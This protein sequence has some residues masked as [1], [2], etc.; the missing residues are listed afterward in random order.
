MVGRLRLGNTA[1]ASE[2]DTGATGTQALRGAEAWSL[3]SNASSDDLVNTE[4]LIP[5]Q[6]GD[7]EAAAHAGADHHGLGGGA[8]GGDGGGQVAGLVT[9]KHLV[10]DLGLA[11]AREVDGDDLVSEGCEGAEGVH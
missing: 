3:T 8:Q 7:H 6:E 5:D 9:S 10:S 1:L 4:H 2:V 11:E